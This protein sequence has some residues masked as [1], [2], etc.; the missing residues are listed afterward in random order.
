MTSNTRKAHMDQ[1]ISIITYNDI[2][3]NV[4]GYNLFT[5]LIKVLPHGNFSNL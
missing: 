4:Y 2:K 3:I 5:I 1:S